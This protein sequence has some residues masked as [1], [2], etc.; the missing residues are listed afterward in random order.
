MTKTISPRCSFD[1][2]MDIGP[3]ASLEEQE[4]RKIYDESISLFVDRKCIFVSLSDFKNASGQTIGEFL[5]DKHVDFAI[6]L[7]KET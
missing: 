6:A 1:C 7:S 2:E 3:D 5:L 4:I